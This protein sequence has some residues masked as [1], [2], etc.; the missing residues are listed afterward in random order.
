MWQ[1]D[2][3]PAFHESEESIRQPGK[4]GSGYKYYLM[5]PN[6]KNR[7]HSQ[8]N[9]LQLIKNFSPEPFIYLHPKDAEENGISNNDIIRIY[10]DRG[11]LK[12]PV[13]FDS[14][15]KP[16]CI[17]VTN[18]WWISEGGTVNFCSAGRETD[19]GHG[20]A[21]HDNLVAVERIK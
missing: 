17:C 15:L 20:A 16:G 3:L 1:V 13:R 14:G 7:I 4:T 18:G 11:E 6:T 10:N 19:M 9:N 21:F 8:F 2:T 12:L 5:T